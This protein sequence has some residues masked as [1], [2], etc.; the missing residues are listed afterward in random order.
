MTSPSLATFVPLPPWALFC[1]LSVAL[2]ED[3]RV[4]VGVGG[5]GTIAMARE[6]PQRGL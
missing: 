1:F 3:A 5:R 4:G 2:T 6:E